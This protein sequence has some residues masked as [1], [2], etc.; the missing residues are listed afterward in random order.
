MPSLIRLLAAIAVLVALVYG[1]AY[2]LA[3]KVEPVTRDVTITVP[4]DRFQK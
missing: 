2:W 3:T 1:G 4:N